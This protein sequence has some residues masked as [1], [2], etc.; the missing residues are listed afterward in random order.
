ML[1]VRRVLCISFCSANLQKEICCP[2]SHIQHM[3]PVMKAETAPHNPHNPHPAPHNLQPVPY[4]PPKLRE[5]PFW[6]VPWLEIVMAIGLAVGILW[7]VSRGR[8]SM[9]GFMTFFLFAPGIVLLGESM[10]FSLP[11]LFLQIS[12]FWWDVVFLVYGAMGAV[13]FFVQWECV[14]IFSSFLGWW[15]CPPWYPA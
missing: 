9:S 15:A 1:K 6:R 12:N 5:V 13:G 11:L 2:G 4:L 14:Y 10:L 8:D 7:G 3:I